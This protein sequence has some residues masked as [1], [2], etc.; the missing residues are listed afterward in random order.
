MN[1]KDYPGILL[2][3]AC[4]LQ[5]VCGKEVIA[6]KSRKLADDELV[7]DW[8]YLFETLLQF[9]MWMRKE[10]MKKD[11]V[12]RC[13]KKFQYLMALYRK[14]VNRTKGMGLKFVKFH[15]L[16]HVPQEILDFGIPLEAD[17]GANESGH[18]AEKKAARLTQRRKEN[19][20]E[21]TNRRMMYTIFSK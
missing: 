20:E 12:I 11:L 4:M 5:S 13:K 18:K 16:L 6:D 15:G 21:Q 19:F 1:A 2:L 7:R 10:S 9:E 17:T 14:V 3:L 8:Q